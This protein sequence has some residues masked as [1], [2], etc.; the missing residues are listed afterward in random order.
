MHDDSLTF[1]GADEVSFGKSFVRVLAAHLALFLAIW[2]AGKF[3]FKRPVAEPIVWLDGGGE[4]GSAAAPEQAVATPA[5]PVPEPAETLP[6]IPKEDLLP[7]KETPELPIVVKPTP[8]PKPKP[9]PAPRPKPTPT[10]TPRAKPATPAPK[11]A[12]STTPVPKKK[13]TPVIAKLAAPR[14]GAKSTPPKITDSAASAAGSGSA[15]STA[16]S[17]SGDAVSAG[18]KGAPGAPGGSDSVL[19]GYFKK[20]ES[21]F[22][23]EW[24]QPLT[25]VR[26]GRDVEAHVHLRAAADGTVESLTLFKPTGNHEVDQSIEAALRRVHKVERPPAGLLKNGV[27]DETVAFVLEL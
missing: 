21:Q 24:Q 16:A 15:K 19:L 14:P 18:K 17:G 2:L 7:P 22:Q 26:S 10:P 13:P 1:S 6:P 9:T 27:L 4:L 5:S 25:V 3:Y 8:T 12:V 11:P 23:Q 20:V